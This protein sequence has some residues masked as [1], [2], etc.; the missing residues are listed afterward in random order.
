MLSDVNVICFPFSAAGVNPFKNYLDYDSSKAALDMVTKQFAL[1]LGAH[2]IRVNS[3]NL[4]VVWTDKHKQRQIENPEYYKRFESITP[5]GKLCELQ[6]AHY[7]NM[8]V[9]YTAIFHG[10]KNDYFQMKNCN[11]FLIFAQNIDC[12]YTL[13]PPL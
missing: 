4:T 12:G 8:S 3:I 10:Y 2:N 11:I 6:E 7:A 1:D 13:E 5:L 9:Q